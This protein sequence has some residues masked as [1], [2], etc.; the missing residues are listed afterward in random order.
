MPRLPEGDRI[1]LFKFRT[2]VHDWLN[3]LRWP[4]DRTLRFTAARKLLREWHWPD[5]RAVTWAAIHREPE[6]I[7]VRAGDE[8]LNGQL[9][10]RDWV[11][12]AAH[13][14][15]HILAADMDDWVHRMIECRPCEKFS[16]AEA[17]DAFR[18]LSEEF[19]DRVALAL[20]DTQMMLEEARGIPDTGDPSCNLC[21]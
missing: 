21:W 11:S 8:V 12:T 5:P 9:K 1:M 20:T 16:E 6:S 19:T 14:A 2:V 18:K 13:E 3:R 17:T 15:L 10:R 7:I 4:G